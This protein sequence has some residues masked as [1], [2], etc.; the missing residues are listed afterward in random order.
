MPVN[1]MLSCSDSRTPSTST[2][3]PSGTAASPT[4]ISVA[5]QVDLEVPTVAGVTEKIGDRGDEPG[6]RGHG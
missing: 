6:E 4:S 1:T 2:V 3:A 5:A